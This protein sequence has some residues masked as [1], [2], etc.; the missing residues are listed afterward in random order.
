MAI[1]RIDDD[2][3]A[4]KL[5]VLQEYNVFE[6]DNKYWCADPFLYTNDNKIYVFCECY[7][8]D[9]EK[10]AIAVAEYKDDKICNLKIVLE[11]K[12]HLSYPCIF[13]HN[14]CLY[15]IPETCDNNTVEL[16]RAT[17]F[18][19]EWVLDT[20]L[21]NDICCV[22]ATVFC[23]ESEFYVVGFENKGKNNKLLIFHL[24]MDNKTL[25]SFAQINACNTERPAGNVFNI[26]DK[27][28]RPSQDCRKKYGGQIIMNE[29]MTFEK[30]NYHEKVINVLGCENIKIKGKYKVDR[31]HTINRVQSVE[32]IDF[33]HDK[34]DVLKVLK[35]IKSKVRKYKQ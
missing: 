32:V 6:P 8:K 3:T 31:I 21:K 13:E 24:D 14:N 4:K 9:K 26:D 22:D 33:S 11:Q 19:D 1:R 15:M 23:K 28:I 29:I 10:G 34:I 5:G 7:V 27:I 35:L 25:E 30:D 16:Y 12:Y 17:K 2:E 18:P 20:V